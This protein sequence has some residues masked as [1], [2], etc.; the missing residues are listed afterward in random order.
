MLTHQKQ[1]SL[2]NPRPKRKDPPRNDFLSAASLGDLTAAGVI[3]AD[4]RLR[5]YSKIVITE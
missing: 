2:L 1:C 3:E 5:I 4:T